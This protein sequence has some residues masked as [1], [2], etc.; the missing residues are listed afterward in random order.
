MSVNNFRLPAL[1]VLL[2]EDNDL[3]R[4]VAEAI[5]RQS[6][7]Q[8][9]SCGDGAAAVRA[10]ENGNFDVVFMDIQMPTMDGVE[11][12]RR[13]R[14]LAD[15]RKARIPVLALTANFTEDE[16]DSCLAAGANEIVRKPLRPGTIEVV[17][18]PL[19]A[20]PQEAPAEAD[21]HAAE[22][23]VVDPAR[24]QLLA[25]SL[26]PVR[27]KELYAVARRSMAESAA[28]LRRSWEAQDRPATGRS[29]H[30]LAG[31]A[32]NFGCMA[33]A[34]LA[35]DIETECRAGGDGRSRQVRFE[36]LLARSLAALPDIA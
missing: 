31:V 36:A 26:D 6:G 28:E 13:I 7:H 2:V 21:D 14:S 3:T 30:R 15:R 18:A 27:L 16:A 1:S 8:V 32:S 24:T 20:L 12:T 25:E 23:P 17:L 35:A 10:V 33:L 34:R 19:F 9:Q 4:Q 29:A 11:A 22:L 5:L